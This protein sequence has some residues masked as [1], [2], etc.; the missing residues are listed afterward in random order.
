MSQHS[1][2]RLRRIRAND[3]QTSNGTTSHPCMVSVRA[4]HS[5]SSIR[6]TGHYGSRLRIPPMRIKSHNPLPELKTLHST[7]T[8]TALS[9]HYMP[10]AF[11]IPLLRFFHCFLFSLVALSTTLNIR[12]LGR[13]TGEKSTTIP[14]CYRIHSSS[15]W[16]IQR[17]W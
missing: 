15:T 16:K 5:T 3:L 4:D 17:R 8:S 1:C 7:M 11:M 10:S 9:S 6:Q 12:A 2:S 13:H 14:A